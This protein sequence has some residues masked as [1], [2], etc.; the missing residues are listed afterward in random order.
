[1]GPEETADR[2]HWVKSFAALCLMSETQGS[3]DQGPTRAYFPGRRVILVS[4][5]LQLH[6]MH[7]FPLLGDRGFHFFFENASGAIAI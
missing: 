5:L 4:S 2:H 1:M 7:L 3:L 6:K